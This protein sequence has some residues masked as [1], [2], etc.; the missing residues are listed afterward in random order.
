MKMEFKNAIIVILLL[1]VAWLGWPYLQ[2]QNSTSSSLMSS[3]SKNDIEFFTY[4]NAYK[5]LLPEDEFKIVDARVNKVSE[6][7]NKE[8]SNIKNTIIL[9]YA[10]EIN[11]DEATKKIITALKE[12][13]DGL[14]KNSKI[15]ADTLFSKNTECAKLTS[16]I[17]EGL[18][19]KY[20]SSYSATETE[21]LG[22]IFYSPTMNTCIYSTDYKYSYSNYTSGKSEYYVKN[23]NKLYDVSSNK[24][25]GDFPN[26]YYKYPYMSEQEAKDAVKNGQKSYAKFVFENSGYNAKL[27]KDVAY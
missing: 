27:L 19:K 16:N 18:S 5:S 1:A 2:G 23:S 25:L 11:K 17:Q 22:I 3:S 4:F 13:V 8:D 14:K 12:Q 21:D 15:D 26:Y 10:N 7:A 6:E 24:Q 20:K 9:S